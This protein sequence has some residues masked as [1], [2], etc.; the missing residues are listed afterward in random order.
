MTDVSLTASSRRTL[1]QIQRTTD[2]R[3]QTTLRIASGQRINRPSDDPPA[4]F[5]AR[6]LSNR[7]AGLLETRNGIGQALSAVETAQVGVEAI[8]DLANQLKGLALSVRGADAAS[9]QAATEQ[10]DVL[11][12]QL[13]ALASD[14]G[15]DGVSLLADDRTSLA[16]P[17]NET[18]T[19]TATING[20]AADAA[21][22]GIGS[23]AGS[24]NSFAS[25]A[26]IATAVSQLDGALS[27]LH[28]RA[29]GLGGGI[30][31]LNTRDAFS[32]DLGNTLQGGVDKLVNADFNEESARLLSLRLRD[33]LGIFGQSLAARNATLVADLISG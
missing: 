11:R 18:G 26:D 8:S 28:T 33:Q 2:L 12:G 23:A 7:V 27:T 22:L 29:A 9:R 16:V 17:L 25:D 3:Q 10:F 31:L 15:F 24:L 6:G 14:A 19:A 13:S 20:A 5:Q 21:S 4:Y 30:S 32:A 1:F